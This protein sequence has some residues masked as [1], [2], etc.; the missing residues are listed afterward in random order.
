LTGIPN[1]LDVKRV[2]QWALAEEKYIISLC[3]GPACLLAASVDEKPEDFIFKGYEIVF[4]DAL[5]EG[6]DQDIGYM[7]GKMEWVVGER[8]SALGVKMLN[9]GISGQCHQ[10]RK[11]ITGDSPLASNQLGKLAAAALLQQVQTL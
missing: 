8:L 1:S 11:P 2:L 10:D 6:A 3:Q 9:D 7:P 4:P 5:D